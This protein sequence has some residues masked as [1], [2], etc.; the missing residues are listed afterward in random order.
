MAA[1]ISRELV[2]SLAAHTGDGPLL[3]LYLPTTLKVEQRQKNEIR[4]KNLLK[5]ARTRLEA[6]GMAATDADLLT[7]AVTNAS[8]DKEMWKE[9]GEG[10]AV[11]A[12]RGFLEHVALPFR[13]R[14]LAVVNF[15]FHLKPLLEALSRRR[16]FWLLALSQKDVRLYVGDERTVSDV[17]VGPDV[18]R[19]LTDVTGGQPAGKQLRYHSTSRGGD[20]SVYHGMGAGKDDVEPEQEQFVRAV[21]DGLERFW[22]ADEAPLITAG[23]N[24]LLAMYRRLS[25]CAERILGEV[26]GNVEDLDRQAL[27]AKAWPIVEGELERQRAET[28]ARLDQSDAQTPVSRELADIV[29]AA[30]DGRV[31]TLFVAMDREC[32][33]RWD[34]GERS[35]E[36]HERPLPGDDDLLDRAAV[37]SW[38]KGAAVH[39]VPAA[40]IPGGGMAIAGLRY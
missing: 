4:L 27:H 35:I 39:A 34:D 30:R 1:D 40:E 5:E 12:G 19:R 15:R 31:D 24:P 13:V 36:S 25:D 29:R 28:L 17:D 10:F 33:G 6:L 9:H 20:T 3:S 18:P 2:E 32:W 8:L 21:A 22:K 14:E 7:K 38:L 26:E 16:R 37:E 11:F 23:D